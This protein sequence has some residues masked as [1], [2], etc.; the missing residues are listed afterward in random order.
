MLGYAFANPAYGLKNIQNDEW[1]DKINFWHNYTSTNLQAI[2]KRL[3]DFTF[4]S[5]RMAGRNSNK[6]TESE[7]VRLAALAIKRK[8]IHIPDKEILRDLD[9]IKRADVAKSREVINGYLTAFTSDFKHLKAGDI[10]FQHGW[11]RGNMRQYFSEDILKAADEVEKEYIKKAFGQGRNRGD[12]TNN[13]TNRDIRHGAPNSV[14]R[15]QVGSGEIYRNIPPTISNAL[16]INKR[17]NDQRTL[18]N[19]PR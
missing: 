5:S 19:I 6:L 3:E 12:N 8:D 4:N 1:G 14:A 13:R 7:K 11:H 10:V 18:L 9:I 2:Q 15:P 17:G 16:G